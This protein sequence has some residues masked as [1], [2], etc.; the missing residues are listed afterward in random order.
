MS[1]LKKLIKKRDEFLKENPEFVELQNEIDDMLTI[2]NKEYEIELL[3]L[4]ISCSLQDFGESLL[5]FKRLN[6]NI[7]NKENKNAS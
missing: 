4:L 3:N 2:C 5:K 6:L 7:L 1:N